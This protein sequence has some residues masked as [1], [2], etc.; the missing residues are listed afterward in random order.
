MKLSSV[1]IVETLA[2]TVQ[3]NEQVRLRTARQLVRSA[4]QT[5]GLLNIGGWL[6]KRTTAPLHDTRALHWERV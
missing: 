1:E 6:F 4:V 3:G 5:S 2:G